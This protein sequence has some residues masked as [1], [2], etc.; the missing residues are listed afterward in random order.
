MQ[1]YEFSN[2][3]NQL[4]LNHPSA[5]LF[6]CKFAAYLQKSFFEKHIQG[7]TYFCKS[8]FNM[9]PIFLIIQI[10]VK[11]GLFSNTFLTSS[12]F[13]SERTVLRLFRISFVPIQTDLLHV[14]SI[15]KSFVGLSFARW[16]LIKLLLNCCLN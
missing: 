7:T 9:P 6:S 13:F 12:M 2:V 1:K 15:L 16:C 8:S 4:Y 14:I 10:R 11:F 5:W 3:I